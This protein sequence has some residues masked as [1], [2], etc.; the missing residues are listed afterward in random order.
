[1]LH[2]L[3]LCSCSRAYCP[4]VSMLCSETSAHLDDYVISGEGVEH[5]AAHRSGER[6]VACRQRRKHNITDSP[7]NTARDPHCASCSL[8]FML[9]VLHAHVL[10]DH[11]ASRTSTTVPQ[12]CAPP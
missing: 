1:V 4:A 10:Q 7:Y 9:T 11:C 8:C 6:K 12:R 2:L 5:V 3:L